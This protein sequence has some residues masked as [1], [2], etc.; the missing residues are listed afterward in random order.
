MK[1]IL[2][3]VAV[4]AV[5]GS[6]SALSNQPTVVTTLRLTQ[7]TVVATFKTTLPVQGSSPYLQGSS[8]DLQ[9]N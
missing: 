1:Y 2:A 8:P 6:A 9:G 7:P 5:A 4:L 3:I